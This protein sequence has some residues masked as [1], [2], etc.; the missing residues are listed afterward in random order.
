MEVKFEG[1]SVW[2]SCTN[3]PRPCWAKEEVNQSSRK[4]VAR[5]RSEGCHQEFSQNLLPH[6]TP[7]IWSEI[8]N[9]IQI[10][11]DYASLSVLSYFTVFSFP[12]LT[13]PCSLFLPCLISVDSW[14][15]STIAVKSCSACSSVQFL[16]IHIVGL[17]VCEAKFEVTLTG[18]LLR[19]FTAAK[20]TSFGLL[21]KYF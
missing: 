14:G 11:Q 17:V 9:Q 16:F 4:T 13:F 2:Q 10:A 8:L 15:C 1:P 19:E 20:K 12:H 21:S 5:G 6:L 7:S 3:W 18:L